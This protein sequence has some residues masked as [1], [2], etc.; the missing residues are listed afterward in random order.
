LDLEST[1]QETAAIAAEFSKK[2][3]RMVQGLRD[4]GF[5]IDLP[6]EGSFYVWASAAH[7][8]ASI[9]DGMR[10]FRAALE[11]KVIA[12]PGEFF[13]V[14]PG[15]RRSGQRSRFKQHLRFS[16]GPNMQTIDLALSRIR[17]LIASAASG[18]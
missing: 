16:F 1:K 13:D 12:V 7:L 15:R 3:E 5:G 11:K 10:F 8:P 4:L 9:N 6:P 2:R 14:N 17:E 18:G